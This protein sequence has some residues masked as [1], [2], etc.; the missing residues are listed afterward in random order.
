MDKK[1]LLKLEHKFK[2][3]EIE[4]KRK[5]ELEIETL[6]HENEMTR[7]RIKSAEIRK[8]LQRRSF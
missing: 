2:M 4:T 6:K 7:Q 8:N 3:K 5:A 1:E